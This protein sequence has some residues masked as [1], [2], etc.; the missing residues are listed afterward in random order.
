LSP[1]P[2]LPVLTG[3]RCSSLGSTWGE[4]TGASRAS[5]TRQLWFL[6]NFDKAT[7]LTA[8]PQMAMRMKPSFY[9]FVQIVKTSIFIS[10]FQPLPVT[11]WR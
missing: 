8:G 7:R 6:F 9:F 4:T 3:E 2:D 11:Q 10:L 5:V 1:A